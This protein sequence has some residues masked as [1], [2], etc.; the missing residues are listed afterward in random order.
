MTLLEG[1]AI[2]NQHMPPCDYPP[3]LAIDRGDYWFFPDPTP[4]VGFR[5]FIL[6]KDGK[7]QIR[8]GSGLNAEMAFWAYEKGILQGPCDLVITACPDDLDIVVDILT[9]TAPSQRG[10]KIP[11]RGREK[12]YQT[13]SNLPAVIFAG[14]N[15]VFHVEELMQAEQAGLF[16]FAIRPSSKQAAG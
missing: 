9:K 16:A 10:M 1:I 13:L 8:V 14:E 6:S 4:W 5:G 7:H 15:L 2:R 11:N 3:K 12:W